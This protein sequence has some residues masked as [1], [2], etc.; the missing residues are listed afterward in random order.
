MISAGSACPLQRTGWKTALATL[1]R[2]PRF[3]G[4]FYN[5]YE[6]R[7]L[8]TLEPKYISS[9]DSGNLAGHLL[10]LSQACKEMIEFPIMSP[11]AQLGIDDTVRLLRLA[12]QGLG[13]D[14]TVRHLLDVVGDI[15]SRTAVAPTGFAAHVS[16]WD[17]LEA[18]A[19]TVVAG[20]RSLTEGVEDGERNE[21]AAWA[22]LL[23]DD[24]RSHRSD[25]DLLLPWARLLGKWIP[26]RKELA[27]EEQD[28]WNAFHDLL[29]PVIPLIAHARPL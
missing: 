10:A 27:G 23:L 26:A 13:N 16:F 5:W 14:A 25:I 8:R 1:E 2:L 18:K 4:H 19:E 20:A 11:A 21:A 9:V 3:R 29:T 6:T 28:L 15:K 12:L 22:E 7:E 24:I 17:T